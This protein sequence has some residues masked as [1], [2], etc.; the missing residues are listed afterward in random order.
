MAHL[1]EP[2]IGFNE[3]RKMLD[4]LVEFIKSNE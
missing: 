3:S 1:V 2:T 4:D